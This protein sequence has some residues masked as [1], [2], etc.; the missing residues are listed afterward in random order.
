MKT[1]TLLAAIFMTV[2]AAAAAAPQKKSIHLP[3]DNAMARLKP[4]PGLDAVKNN[5]GLCHSTD[6]IVRQPRLEAKKWEA[7]VKKMMTV[8]GA[9]VSEA[10]AKE[11]VDYLSKNYGS[12]AKEEPGKK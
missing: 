9:P 2:A 12:K 5:C 11:I 6:Y 4:G 7:E 3:N 8:F 1:L 10:D